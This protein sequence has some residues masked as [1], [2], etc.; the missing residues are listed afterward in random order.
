MTGPGTVTADPEFVEDVR[1]GLTQEQ[2]AIPPRWLYDPRGSELFEQITELDAYYL[3]RTERALFETHAEGIIEA[4][5]TPVEIV[6][7]GAG[8]AAKTRLILQAAVHR[9]GPTTYCP[10]DISQAAIE[11]A[12]QQLLEAF[13]DELTIRPVVGGYEDG[14]AKLQDRDGPPCLILFIGSSIGN[15]E[16]EDQLDLLTRIAEV[17]GPE[18]RFLL[19]TDMAKDEEIL[20]E[21]YDDPQ[22]VTKAFATNLLTRMNRELGAT[23]DEE[24]FEFVALYNDDEHRIEMYLESQQ[25]KTVH[26]DAL[27]L[28]VTFEAGERLHT[29]HSYKYTEPLIDDLLDEAGLRRTQSWYDGKR[30]FGV[31]LLSSAGR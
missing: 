20:L 17:M 19:G 28:D 2:K 1:Q 29:E 11:M 12:R 10:I 21:A 16:L 30:W 31:H 23:F 7:L 26:I 15:F 27:D 6:E 8:S 13:P 3:T 14:L 4:C 22:G 25:D 5:P 18:D 24:T 9:Q